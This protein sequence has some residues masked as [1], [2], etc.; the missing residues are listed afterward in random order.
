VTEGDDLTGG[1][2][3]EFDSYYDEVYKFRTSHKDLPVNLKSP[4]EDVPNEQIDYIKGYID[5]IESILYSADFAQNT[6][7]YEQL[8]DVDSYVDRWILN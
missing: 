2:L 7:G 6:R 5:N 1:Y 8:I 4:D 3:L